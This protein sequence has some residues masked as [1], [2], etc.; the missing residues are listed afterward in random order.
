MLVTS[1][2]LDRKKQ[3]NLHDF[4]NTALGITY[5][6]FK[7]KITLTPQFLFIYLLQCVVIHPT[8]LFYSISKSRQFLTLQEESHNGLIRLP[9]YPVNPLGDNTPS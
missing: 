9:M 3:Q 7:Q 6:L 8:T 1:C 5:G 2:P 4:F